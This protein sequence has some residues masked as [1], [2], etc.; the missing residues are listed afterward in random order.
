MTEPPMTAKLSAEELATESMIAALIAIG[1][2]AECDCGNPA[3]CVGAYEGQDVSVCCD[4]CCGHGNEDG[5][6][7]SLIE[8][9]DPI[10][11]QLRQVAALTAQVREAEAQLNRARAAMSIAMDALES[12]ADKDA[13]EKAFEICQGQYEGVTGDDYESLRD[14]LNAEH[15]QWEASGYGVWPTPPPA[16]EG[17]ER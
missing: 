7:K 13:R 10:Y 4:V 17:S 5:S 12:D 15:A 16:R 2:N 6:C 11:T 9:L 8:T 1:A 14:V 3:S